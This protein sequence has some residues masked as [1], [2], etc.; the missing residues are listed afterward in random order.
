MVVT[1]VDWSRMSLVW[2][3]TSLSP[4]PK[5]EFVTTLLCHHFGFEVCHVTSLPPWAGI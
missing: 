3:V 4:F 1:R 5:S 2:H